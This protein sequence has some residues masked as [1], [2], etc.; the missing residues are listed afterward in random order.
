[1]RFRVGREVFGEAVAWVARALPSRPVVPVLSGLLLQA[2]EEDGLTLSCFDYEISARVRIAADVKEPGSALVPGRLLADIT[3]SLPA[4]DVE[5]ATEADLVGL[6]C[7]SAEFGLVS[8]PVTEYPALPDPPPTAGTVDGGVLA[9]AAAQVVP[10]ASRDDTLPMLTAV[11]LDI[12]GETLTLAATDRYRMAV[13]DVRWDPAA[14]G[15][16]A[17]AM[18]P[19]RTL[20]DVAKTMAAGVAVTVAFG[21]GDQDGGQETAAGRAPRDPRP[22]DGVISFEGGDRRLTARLIGGEFIKYRSRFPAEF[23]SRALVPAGPF[24]EAVRRVSLVAERATPVRLTFGAGNVVI[25]AQTDG[26]ARATETVPADFEGGERTISFS[27]HYLLDGLS[28][29]AAAVTARPSATPRGEEDASAADPGQIRLEFTTAA[30]PALITWAGDEGLGSSGQ[31]PAFRYL[32][33]PLRVPAA[34]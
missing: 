1:M 33:V 15:L 21:A 30:K 10:A 27:P 22:A 16:R 6:T 18:V 20:A 2:D 28:A 29:A 26:R 12:D 24:T 11:C 19:A 23:G 9:V 4:V 31:G 3:R 8:L 7:G 17:T 14:P 5:V 32:V 34:A 13:R 25:E